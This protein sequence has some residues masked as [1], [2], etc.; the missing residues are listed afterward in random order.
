MNN[1]F[2]IA[3]WRKR[4]LLNE[5]QNINRSIIK[6]TTLEQGQEN[7]DGKTE[8][9]IKNRVRRDLSE[10]YDLFEIAYTEE[11][12]DTLVEKYINDIDSYDEF[13]EYDTDKMKS[14]ELLSDFEMYVTNMNSNEGQKY[15]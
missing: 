11:E 14:E 13:V 4:Y 6:N 3:N 8:D 2:N 5:N 15:Y 10:F 12:Y 9:E 1:N 7:G